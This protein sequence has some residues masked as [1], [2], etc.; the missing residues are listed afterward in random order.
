[1]RNVNY[2]NAAVTARERNMGKYDNMIDMPRPEPR[3]RMSALERA[4]QFAPFAA[5]TGYGESVEEAARIVGERIELSDDE[6]ERLDRNTKKI[7]EFPDREVAVTYFIADSRKR[8]GAYCTKRGFVRWI[9]EAARVILMS[10]GGEI[11]LDDVYDIDFS[12]EQQTDTSHNQRREPRD[13]ALL[14]DNPDSPFS[15]EFASD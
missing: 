2:H 11:P 10:D 14:N 3:K 15:A 5:L 13:S 8:G 7:R 12:D 1:M 9:D 4:A 6:K